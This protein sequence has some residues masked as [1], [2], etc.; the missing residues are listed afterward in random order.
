MKLVYCSIFTTLFALSQ[1]ILINKSSWALNSVDFSEK[2][3]VKDGDVEISMKDAL[4]MLN[5]MSVSQRRRIKNDKLRLEQL[6]LNYTVLKKKA[7]EASKSDVADDPLTKWKIRIAQDRILVNSLLRKINNSTVVP[8]DAILKIATE[9]YDANPSNYSDDI[10]RVAHILFSFKDDEEKQLKKANKVLKALKSGHEF[11]EAVKKYSDDKTTVSTGGDLGYFS[12]GKMVPAFDKIA[13]SL[14]KV[15]GLSDVV[16]T[17]FGFHIIKLLDRRNQPVKSRDI[18][19]AKIFDKETEQY[20]SSALNIYE[21][22]FDTNDDTIIFAP[23][24]DMLYT[25][26]MAMDTKTLNVDKK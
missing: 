23:V 11:S 26:L 6:V 24:L 2:V 20:L 8:E 3:L 9:K 1:Y 22:K 12:R 15:E 21:K 13:F 19:I 25:N 18:A 10:I 5:D 16:K 14:S 17:K 7:L 4:L